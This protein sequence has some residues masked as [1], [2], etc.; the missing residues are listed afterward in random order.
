[1]RLVEE[2]ELI[3]RFGQAYVDYRQCV[4]AFWPRLRDLKGFFEFLIVG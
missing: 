2:K 1:V 4:P 3:E